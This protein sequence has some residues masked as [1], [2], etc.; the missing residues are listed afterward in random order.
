MG[1]A[2][3]PEAVCVDIIE[4]HP[5][6]RAGEH[7]GPQGIHV[8]NKV[9][10]N[11]QPVYLPRDSE[12]TVVASGIRESRVTMTFMARRVRLGHEDELLEP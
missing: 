8:V 2:E 12:I 7:T 11:G 1:A 5:Q 10:I 3:P 6:D 9:V 4:T